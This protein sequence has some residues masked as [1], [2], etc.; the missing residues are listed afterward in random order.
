MSNV[1]AIRKKRVLVFTDSRGQHKPAGQDHLIFG[2][3]M[4]ADPR[5]DVDLYLCPMKWTTTLDF[6]EMFSVATLRSYDAVVLWTGI[7][8]WS[9][10]PLSSAKSD[11]YN[12]SQVSNL[13]GVH[14]NTRDYSRKAVNNKRAIF[15]S[16]FGESC[17]QD[18]FERPY[19]VEY[20][21]ER[22][23]NMYGI[24]MVEQLLLRLE[25]IPNLIYINANRFVP[26]WEG[27]FK[28]GRPA[29][30]SLTHEYSDAFTDRL[31]GRVAA[32]IDLHAW[33]DDEV[34]KY[35]CDNI[36]V[37]KDGSDY[38]YGKL[39]SALRLSP[40]DES[41][42]Q[43]EVVGAQVN[44]GK[45]R[46]DISDFGS[47]FST[48]FNPLQPIE[49]MVGG[50]QGKIIDAVKA[51]DYLATLIIGFRFRPGDEVR[52]RNLIFLMDWL[53]YNYG[54]LFDILL[55][56]QDA[57]PKFGFEGR[58]FP[59]HVRY[60][61]IYNP[62]EY[63]RGWGYNV[64]VKHFCVDSKVVVLMDTDVLTGANFVREVMDC[65]SKFDVIS[66][67]QN[68]YYTS[69]DEAER[70]YRTRDVGH[71][72]DPAAIKNPVTVAGGIL[73]AKRSV[74]L[75]M[76]GFEQYVGYGCEDRALDVTLFNHI[77]KN[78]IRIAPLTYVHL[79]HP[80][81]VESRV[82]F[83]E[84]Y[85]HLVDNYGCKY[86][87]GLGPFDFIHKACNHVAPVRTL[88][89]ML[90][91]AKGFADKDLY[92][93][94]QELTVNG[95]GVM[96]VNA[97]Q[98]DVIYPPDFST[99]KQ[100]KEKEI[101]KAAPEPD[102]DELAAF[103]N[104]YRGKRC[105]IIGNG[106]SLNEHDL[107]LLEGEYTFGV[108]SFYY[109]TRETGFVP[110]FYV[111]EDSSVMKENIEEIRAYDAP[112][113]FFPTNYKSLHPK[114]PNTFFFRMNRSFYEKSSPNYVVPR[115]STDASDV[116]YCGQSVTYINL[117]L[118]YF[119]GFEEV[120]LIGMDFSYVIPES[121]ARTGDV[122]LSDTDDPNHFHKDYFG[123]GKTWKDPK[124]DRVALN[125][126][127]A[128]ATYEA[129]GRRIFNATVGGSLEVFDRVDYYSLFGDKA[130]ARNSGGIQAVGSFQAANELFRQG[131]YPEALSQY[132]SLA[133]RE[134]AF[135][136]YKRA[137][138]DAYMR[139]AE[140]R[141]G[142]SASDVAYVRGLM[143]G[144]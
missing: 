45:V 127:M 99:L 57:S 6:L 58:R 112:F 70:V 96:G 138:V 119:M 4:K 106:P 9:P 29:N 117:Q 137:A 129:T 126:K 116:L 144:M 94:Q 80:R 88:E 24:S 66:P 12:N 84:I 107:S 61:F 18:H 136:Q 73:I 85:A 13:D 78:K 121:H 132:V 33:T 135:A 36:H 25:S 77:P 51:K 55:V 39:M 79:Y 133:K 97:S 27:D 50:K 21:G 91:R 134:S 100:Y 40:I 102:S 68:I 122:L 38:I 19:E 20:A 76:K 17:M 74:Y 31:N 109:K 8:D 59:P 115:F 28:K 105:F 53:E 11:L 120:Y 43:G 93:R 83:K 48:G 143:F 15:D 1:G 125:Y 42:C 7:V 46:L 69:E 131:R 92:R 2:E 47:D 111:V 142:C 3:R 5:L 86:E 64:A 10:R 104:A 128:K 101:Y 110:F 71:L 32:L 34:K 141:M 118:A 140:K 30:I 35:T 103:Y 41:E 89:L 113:K 65:Y 124:L 67:Y 63:N 130:G 81:D 62:E 14:V 56:E 37:T 139:A 54:G 23:I 75:A 95:S 52:E 90:E 82:R 49:R 123:K 72:L 16:V 44:D 26:G 87:P 108:N 60:E 98:A 114:Q 22:T